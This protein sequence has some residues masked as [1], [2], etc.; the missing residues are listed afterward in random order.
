MSDSRTPIRIKHPFECPKCNNIFGAEVTN[1]EYLYDVAKERDKY[2]KALEEIA[3]MC[4]NPNAVDACRL[5]LNKCQ[6][7]LESAIQIRK[8]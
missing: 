3:P 7:V 2:R 8:Y 4:G 5:I 1:A 6:E